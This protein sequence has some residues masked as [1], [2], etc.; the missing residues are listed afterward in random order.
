MKNKIPQTDNHHHHSHHHHHHDQKEM[1]EASQGGVLK[2]AYMIIVG[3]GLHNFSDGLA[4]GWFSI[5]IVAEVVVF[6]NL[7]TLWTNSTE[8]QSDF[9]TLNLIEAL[10][11]CSNRRFLSK[12]FEWD[13]RF[14]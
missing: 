8:N 14:F 6:K 2:M 12:L 3:D 4:I 10:L 9:M 11:I 5:C 7:F 1:L 13:V